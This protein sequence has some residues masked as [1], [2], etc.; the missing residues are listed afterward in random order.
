MVAGRFHTVPFHPFPSASICFHPAT[1]QAR[2][3]VRKPLL[4]INR[5]TALN[6]PI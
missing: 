3:A 6:R 4:K 5:E 1:M 2:L